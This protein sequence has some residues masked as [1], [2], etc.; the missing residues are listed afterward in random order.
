[1]SIAIGVINNDQLQIKV[2]EKKLSRAEAI[3]ICKE[4][5]PK[6]F[7]RKKILTLTIAIAALVLFTI[8][9]TATGLAALSLCTFEIGLLI[10]TPIALIG[11]SILIKKID[12]FTHYWSGNLARILIQ[13]KE[14]EVRKAAK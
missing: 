4:K 11:I 3:Q 1:M 13:K 8:P 14:E 10:A 12:D 2:E 6:E 9:A 7:R 5:Y